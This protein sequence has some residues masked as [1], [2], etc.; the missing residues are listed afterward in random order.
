MAQWVIG[1]EKTLCP[2]YLNALYLLYLVYL[3]LREIVL[4]MRDAFVEVP[5]PYVKTDIFRCQH[6]IRV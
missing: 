2:A 5:I 3:Y 6:I 4:R 1:I